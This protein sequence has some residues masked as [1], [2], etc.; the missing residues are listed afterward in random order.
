MLVFGMEKSAKQLCLPCLIGAAA[1]LAVAAFGI[2]WLVGGRHPGVREP[3]PPEKE[4]EAMV[5]YGQEALTQRLNDGEDLSAGPCLDNG[6]RFPSWV[7][8]IVHNPREPVDN[9]PEHQCSAYREGRA[10]H[11]IELG[12]DANVVRIGP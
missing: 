1:V 9:I 4:L 5:Q 12:L 10:L 2:W 6:E 8:D 11:F 7:I 3:L